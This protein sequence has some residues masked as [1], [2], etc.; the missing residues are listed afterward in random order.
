MKYFV[1]DDN[2]EFATFLCG[3]ILKKAEERGMPIPCIKEE[4]VFQEVITNLTT[5]QIAE[6]ITS[7]ILTDDIVLFISVN[8]KVEKSNRQ[9]QR[10]IELLK[11]LRL[12]KCNNHCVMYS[13]Q[14]LTGMIKA[15]PLNAILL[16]KGVGFVQLPNLLEGLNTIEK[17]ER[18]N[19]LPFFRA[20]VDLVK[21]RHDEA[22]VYGLEKLKEAYN[23]VFN[24]EADSIMSYSNDLLLETLKYAYQASSSREWNIQS[25]RSKY[26]LIISKKRE[27]KDRYVSDDSLVKSFCDL[28]KENIRRLREKKPTVVFIDDKAKHWSPFLRKILY[29]NENVNDNFYEIIPQT[30]QT[31]DNIISEYRSILDKLELGNKLIDIVIC[32]LKLF[33]NEEHIHDYRLFQSY[34]VINYINNNKENRSTN[35]NYKIKTLLFTAS[36]RL[37]VYK[38]MI[39][40]KY[41]SPNSLFVKEGA[42]LGYTFQQSMENFFGL[43]DALYSPIIANQKADKI[44]VNDVVEIYAEHY[45]KG[46][47]AKLL[48]DMTETD[49]AV[50]QHFSQFTHIVIDTNVFIDSLKKGYFNMLYYL[51]MDEQAKKKII[52]HYTV[53]FELKRNGDEKQPMSEKR[54]LCEFFSQLIDGQSLTIVYDQIPEDKRKELQTSIAASKYNV[55]GIEELADEYLVKYVQSVQKTREN[56]VLFL[57]YDWVKK[58]SPGKIIQDW[59]N[60][61]NYTNVTVLSQRDKRLTVPQVNNWS[62]QK[63]TIKSKRFDPSIGDVYVG[64]V[65]SFLEDKPAAIVELQQGVFGRLFI[66]DCSKVN[67]T[68]EKIDIKKIFELKSTVKVKIK[69]IDTRM[70]F[71]FLEAIEKIV[72]TSGDK[73]NVSEASLINQQ[74]NRNITIVKVSKNEDGEFYEFYLKNSD[75]IAISIAK[76]EGVELLQLIDTFV[77]MTITYTDK[78]DFEAQILSI[79]NSK[80]L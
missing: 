21:I 34:K 29:N 37:S 78:T 72:S 6:A 1:V 24:I 59:I 45:A 60:S 39:E 2:R 75:R 44:L 9:D 23:K 49:N 16:S 48:E 70:R 22:N 8:L 66:S 64:T 80:S 42:D 41:S 52:V 33:Q 76:F 56:K 68:N 40:Q 19:L 13:F 50:K 7:K 54:Y 43:I 63:T 73:T 26:N 10:G 65:L 32:D 15:N 30:G 25:L 27:K 47:V 20:E 38:S 51:L 57:T 71:I 28:M 5:L 74:T 35:K 67:T 61:N 69:N 31:A 12:K 36:N 4:L 62:S 58:N 3:N 77:E 55:Q 11:W 18:E 53:L 14:S 17:A 79:L 46:E